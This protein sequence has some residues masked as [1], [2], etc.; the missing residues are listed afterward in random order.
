MNILK[1]LGNIK[2]T[3]KMVLAMV[4]VGLVPLAIASYVN[5]SAAGTALKDAT[6]NQLGSLRSVKKS[7]I[8][9]YFKRIEN[10]VRTLS[11]SRM[12][13]DAVQE[14]KSAYRSLPDDL[15]VSDEQLQ[16]YRQ[17][18]ATYYNGQFGREFAS[19]NGGSTDTSSLV[20]SSPSSIVSQYLYIAANPSALGSKDSLDY[21]D[22][23]SPYSQT[24][25]K[26]HPA[27]RSYLGKFGFYDIFLVDPESGN[28]VYSVFK[29]I[30][31]GT[32]IT[33][34]PYSDTNFAD[35]VSSALASSADGATLVDFEA[36]LPSYNGPASFIAS[37]IYEGSTL[38]GV[39]VFQ[40]PIG[41]INAIMQE[42]SGLGE[43]G[44][45][46]LVGSDLL[47]RSQSRFADEN[48]ILSTRIE[49]AATAA[50][51]TGAVDA[52]VVNDYRGIPVISSY[53][54][55]SI[56]GVDWALLA[57]I[58]ESEALAA[59][60]SLVKHAVLVAL[61]AVAFVIV[62]AFFFARSMIRPI[63]AAAEVAGNIAEGDLSNSIDTSSGDELGSLLK[64]LSTM[65][66]NLQSRIEADRVAM[67]EA[68]RIRQALNNVNGNVMIADND[69]NI[70]YMNEAVT[71]LFGEVEAEFRQHIP[72]FNASKLMGSCIDVFHK[73][74][75]HQRGL[76]ASLNT[77][78]ESEINVG[79]CTM[80]IVANPVFADDGERLGTVVEWTNRTQEIA[81]EK[82]VQNVVDNALAGDLSNRI[83]LEDKDGFF[84]RLSHGVNELVGVAE[85]VIDDTIRVLSAM[86]DGK[87]TETIDEDY[88]GRFGILKDDANTTV[89]KLTEVVGNI[90]TSAASVKTGADEISQGNTDLSQR[91][92]EQASS[93]EETASSMEE[94]T[95]TVRQN[96]DN[97][98]QA[99]QLAKAAR[100]QAEK[101]GSV[102]N[103]AVTAMGEINASSKKISDIIGVIDEI[104]F[105]T[106]LLALNASVEAARAGEQ[107]RG[108]AVVAS[109]V[110]N[111]AGR[112]ATAAKEIKDLIEDSG[113]KVDEGSRLVNESGETLEEIV[114]GVK[115]VTDIVGEIA[116]ASQ[117]QSA[118]IDEVNKAIT[119]MDELTQQNAALVEEAAAASESL[120]EQ[121]DDLD[122][123]MT[124][125]TVN[126]GA[127]G[128]RSVATRSNNGSERRS[129]DRPWSGDA[130]GGDTQ[131]RPPAA[132]KQVA[133]NGGDQEWEEF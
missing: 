45:T 109:E 22:D 69:L 42:R 44:E 36:Y 94:M 89:A 120:G 102:V 32:S 52:M 7:Q 119:Q 49:T 8:E 70:I 55:L 51:F 124:F 121:A 41:E 60:G 35:A 111:L 118:G 92:E 34:G 63:T 53:A 74:P 99:N 132:A 129:A 67:A 96:A 78:F 80:N 122:Q 91:T 3:G 47:M 66:D 83:A 59:V 15:N 95:S 18:L 73:N 101:G 23:G 113:R 38:E 2:L 84:E 14:F 65:Q 61:G 128:A 112:S 39:L 97:A 87:L 131:K 68:G 103:N 77:T 31:Y 130:P 90:Q 117:E 88:E 72:S 40:M 24:H 86:A 16:E 133:A 75:A 37:P 82:E 127:S 71:E 20:P 46:Y 6:V 57:E 126:G 13:I 93:L 48:T 110:R 21:S 54:Q 26:F 17:K 106:N 62:I 50:V 104:A 107:G 98:G 123:M 108:F 79:D 100:E 64:S 81:I 85:K 30:D 116:A 12:V 27:L 5:S 56:E 58:D 33:T 11:E 25:K 114:T 43:T 115:K 1:K 28:I 105:Q 29:E 4:F 19:Q 10:Q 76:L 125:F 9:N